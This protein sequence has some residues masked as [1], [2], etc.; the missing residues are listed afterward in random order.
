[1]RRSLYIAAVALS[2]TL[3][4][5]VAAR[6]VQAAQANLEYEVKAAFL[7]NFAKFVEWPSTAFVTPEA[8][9]VFCIIGPNP[10]DGRLER[11]VNDRTANGRRIEVR[12]E[13]AAGQTSGCHLIFVPEPEEDVV[14]RVLHASTAAQEA[15]VLTVGET[16]GFAE[17]GGMIEL[18]VDEG[19]V[20]FDINAGA[21]EREGLKLSSQLLKLARRVEK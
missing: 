6:D 4:P 3:L 21:A 5:S 12:E 9:L 15:P 17:A 18:V 13:V 19:R 1:M 10:F 8:P 20:R 2:A 14:A 7:Y 16:Q 11:V